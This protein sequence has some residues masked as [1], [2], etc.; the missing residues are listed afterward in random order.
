[1]FVVGPR[2]VSDHCT[3]DWFR[4]SAAR[5]VNVA[6]SPTSLV[7][8]L[9]M[10]SAGARGETAR[11]MNAVLH[12]GHDVDR[13]REMPG[14]LQRELSR[15]GGEVPVEIAVANRLFGERSFSFQ[16]SFGDYVATQFGATMEWWTFALLSKM[17]G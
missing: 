15:G 9:A 1:M 10:T 11:A 8:A 2:C 3:A 13:T 12:L 6:F 16:R 17:R 4:R 7:I 14:R 5:G